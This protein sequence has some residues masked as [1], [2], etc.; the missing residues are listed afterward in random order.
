MDEEWLG[1][2]KLSATPEQRDTQV[3]ALVIEIESIVAEV[4]QLRAEVNDPG[5]EVKSIH[6]INNES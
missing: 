2:G 6:G 4:R 3:G 1:L 5:C